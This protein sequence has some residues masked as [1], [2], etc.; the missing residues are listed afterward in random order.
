VYNTPRSPLPLATLLAAA[1]AAGC[2]SDRTDAHEGAPLSKEQAQALGGKSDGVD[3]CAYY[4]W[5]G[6]DE[7]DTFCVLPDPDC[8][9]DACATV[10]CPEI[11][12]P[13]CGT[14]GTTYDN[15]CFAG[16]ADATVACEGACP[17]DGGGGGGGGGGGEEDCCGDPADGCGWKGDD[18]CDV[19]CAFGYD[20]DCTAPE[21]PGCP[22]EGCPEIFGP[23]CGTDGVTYVNE[24]FAGCDGV[25]IAC[26]GE[27]PCAG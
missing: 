7:C 8:G 14:D 16:C 23:V 18:I 3:L 9:G 1:L 26:V 20:P 22:N 17:C 15:G 5:Y 21:L 19:G 2:S 27:C 25:Q 6:D 11:W 4:G 12:S 10:G 24:C 13:V